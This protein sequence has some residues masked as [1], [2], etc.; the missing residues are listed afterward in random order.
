[1]ISLRNAAI[2]GLVMISLLVMCKV[3]GDD[4][5]NG[6]RTVTA[7]RIAEGDVT[8]WQEE[9]QGYRA[10][11]QDNLFD[12]I[13]GG[14]DQYISRGLIEGFQQ[15]LEISGSDFS[16]TFLVMD[17]NSDANAKT[18]FDFKA[19]AVST[20]ETAGT[21]SESAAV[22]DIGF[23]SGCTAYAHFG[24]YYLELSFTGYASNK[25]EAKNNAVSFLEIFKDKID[26]M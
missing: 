10:Y 14:A 21:F 26:K 5:D 8:Q 12:I 23:L 19:D 18:M 4:D 13:N 16:A 25:S 24:K 2:F 11:T 9:N 15:I 20:K 1:M 7:L 17:M 3:V 22:I 6:T